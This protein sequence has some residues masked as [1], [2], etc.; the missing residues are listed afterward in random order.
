MSKKVRTIAIV[1]AIFL[2]IIMPIIG[3]Y[4]KIV[5]LEQRVTVTEGNIDTQLQRRSDL[6]PN[7]VETVKGYASQ[8][9]DIFIKVAEA[10]AKLA[11]ATNVTDKAK[12]DSE[13][14]S[15]VSRLLVI[16]EKYP[17]LKSSANFKDLTV[18]LEGS[19]NR[20]GTARQDY[21]TSVGEYNTTIKR[22][23]SNIISGIFGFD[24]KPLYKA[25]ESAKVVPKVNFT[26]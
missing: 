26:K 9:K 2:V 7:L 11:G 5:S 23:P 22:F 8:E 17:D 6:I 14:G 20:I 24:K 13:L 3:G 12:A 4:N 18:A 15:A 1:V 16:V 10:R 19:E 21:N 25:S